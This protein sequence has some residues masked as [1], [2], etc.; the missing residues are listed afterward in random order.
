LAK[1]LW[2]GVALFI[3]AMVIAATMVIQ[4]TPEEGAVETAEGHFRWIVLPQ[5]ESWAL[6]LTFIAALACW[7]TG[8]AVR[9]RRT[10]NAGKP[11][12]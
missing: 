6:L 5:L 9:V 7:I 1:W 8:A 3:V 10:G 4:G 12:S 2:R 11:T